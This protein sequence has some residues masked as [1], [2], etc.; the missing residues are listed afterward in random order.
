MLGNK[1]NV[2]KYENQKQITK[3]HIAI[4]WKLKRYC[5]ILLDIAE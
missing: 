3:N 4:L 2:L 5:I 1:K